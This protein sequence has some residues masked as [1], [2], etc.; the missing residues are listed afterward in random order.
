MYITYDVFW[1]WTFIVAGVEI[2]I[3]GCFI[4]YNHKCI[5]LLQDFA[6]KTKNAIKFLADVN[7]HNADIYESDREMITSELE[8]KQDK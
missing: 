5:K 1:H 8:K 7:D 6:E 4:Y 2:F 3:L